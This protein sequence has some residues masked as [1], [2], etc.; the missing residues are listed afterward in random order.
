MHGVAGTKQNR[1]YWLVLLSL[2][3]ILLAPA[4]AQDE[5]DSGEESNLLPPVELDE[6][7]AQQVEE[8][9]ASA[10]TQRRVRRLGDVPTEEWQPQF[11]SA[12]GSFR[13]G[14]AA[15]LPN[16]E[17][18]KRLYELLDDLDATPGNREV[19][20]ELDALLVDVIRQA[21]RMIQQNQLEEA[22][23]VLDVVKS[24]N[25]D[26][27]GLDAAYGRLND[28]GNDSGQLA[29][30]REAMEDGRVVSPGSNSAWHYYRGVA[31]RDPGNVEAQQGLAQVQQYLVDEALEFA[32]ELDFE[33]TQRMLEEA[34]LV[35][36]DTSLID[37]AEEEINV[38]RQRHAEYLEGQAV[39]AMDNGDFNK[40]ERILVDLVALGGEEVLLGQ[41][42]RRL[43]EARVYGGFKPGQA[44][45]D[46]FL[47]AA[48]WTP[49]TIVIT[50]GSFQM[51]SDSFD[52]GH[53]DNESPEHRVNIRRG[54]AIGKF[55]VSVAEFRHFVERSGY[56]TDAERRGHSIIYN[57]ASGRLTERRDVTWQ[58]SYDGRDADE[59]DPVVHVS[60]NDALAY[61]KWL[62][63]G[64]GKPYRLPSE[65]EFE[66]ALRGG[67]S[68]SYWWGNGTPGRVV[69]NLTGSGDE[70][71]SHR[72]W[73]VAFEGYNDGYWGPAPV[74]SF[75]PNP[76]GLYDISGNVAEW[77]SDCWHETYIRAPAD[78]TAWIN[79]GCGYRVVRGAYWASSPH[80]ARSAFRLS[81][82]PDTTGARV[83]FRIA[84]DL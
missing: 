42:R 77:V 46:H 43:E 55:E 39:A 20:Q 24:V 58:N 13:D 76:F 18:S 75:L 9:S 82:K 83:G 56:V 10:G 68:T 33:S 35:R 30:A 69:E 17:Q 11:D 47:N 45:R 70:S 64:T 48:N 57:N 59:D 21:D 72:T 27:A 63:R 4:F 36:E 6:S 7:E 26:Q 84:R 67:T 19:R 34:R 12:P 5:A 32:R 79:P 74:G 23:A 51:G 49:E 28:R 61:V 50:A 66:Y 53:V 73:T 78:G 62:A 14:G 15:A 1:I 60:W 81:A 40:A 38:I 44:I 52:E 2:L 37:E 54:F 8:E 71:R 29:L 41:L 80:Q 31:D 25:P 3:W 22:E 16:P 65:S